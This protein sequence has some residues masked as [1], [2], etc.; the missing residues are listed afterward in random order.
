MDERLWQKMSEPRPFGKFLNG[1][2]TLL[3]SE[4]GGGDGG[5]GGGG[6]YDPTAWRTS[7]DENLQSDPSLA[8]F[9]GGEK[10]EDLVPMPKQLA[11]A[12]VDTKA[13]VGRDK[14]PMPKTDE[15]WA[16]TFTKL[17]RP[18]NADGYE[19]GLPENTP[20]KVKP[21]LAEDEK[22]FR[23]AA[24]DANLTAAQAKKLW[25]GY[26]GRAL[27]G[28]EELS[29]QMKQEMA[30][31]ETALRAK[32]G[33]SFDA[34]MALANRAVEELGGSELVELIAQTGFG[35]HPKG[36]EMMMK[37]GGLLAEERGIDVNTGE[38]KG[39]ALTIEDKI[40]ANMADNAYTDAS[41]PNHKAIVTQ[42]LKLREQLEEFHN[43]RRT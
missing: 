16:A 4:D 10:G 30:D 32:Y 33:T 20:D 5:G 21:V 9:T 43:Q 24:L 34:R 23:Q 12:F 40:R 28:A 7:L 25:D 15:E 14:I 2:R 29:S 37:L 22:W 41:H 27:K 8:S 17:G 3:F 6:D 38:P 39:S 26:T 13:L 42:T 19:I 11:K 1:L 18:E 36:I 35:R 31:A